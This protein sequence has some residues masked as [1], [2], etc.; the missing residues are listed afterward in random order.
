MNR[1]AAAALP[2]AAYVVIVSGMALFAQSRGIPFLQTN[3][4]YFVAD[5]ARS[6]WEH[7]SLE[8]KE[9][10]EVYRLQLEKSRRD[11]GKVYWQDIFSL[12]RNGK[13]YPTRGVL[14]AFAGAPFYGVFGD[15]G[16]WIMSQVQ[17]FLVLF[18]V[19][20]IARFLTSPQ[21]ALL[22]CGLLIVGTQ[23]MRYSYTF[24]YDVFATA[25]IIC[26]LDLL[27]VKPFLG[28]ALMTAAAE[29]RVN[30]ALFLPFLLLAWLPQYGDRKRAILSTVSGATV[31]AAVLLAMNYVLWGHPLTTGYHRS[32]IFKDG[33]ALVQPVSSEI[34]LR[35]LG[36]DW[37]K[38]L[39][40]EDGGLL[41]Y[42]PILVIFPV[43]LMLARKT[44]FEAVHLALGAA[45]LAQAVFVY[46]LSIWPDNN[47][48]N[49]YLLTAIV[50]SAIPSAAAFEAWRGAPHK[51]TGN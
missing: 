48:A 21:T 41:R 37:G 19:F 15:L 49:R 12:G 36:S 43:G 32:V 22:L 51:E 23:L 1:H 33:A 2:V 5:T 4:Y 26:G 40:G 8:R 28:A 13:L 34:S 50:L 47:N 25:L 44:R 11:P 46:S 45:I 31:A 10:A 6:L 7:G 20:R 30:Y 18:S 24:S 39:I 3:P 38:K 27:R 35:I 29:T 16:F 14:M 17:L 42:N 9:N